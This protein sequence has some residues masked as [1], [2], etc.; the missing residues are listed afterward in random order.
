MRSE[1]NLEYSSFS[2]AFDSVCY[3][4]GSSQVSALNGIATLV[5]QRCVLVL[6]IIHPSALCAQFYG[7]DLLCRKSRY[8]SAV[9]VNTTLI[10]ATTPLQAGTSWSCY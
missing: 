10:K 6:Q 3:H 1:A 4:V 7:R 2:P 8:M 9:F 5:M